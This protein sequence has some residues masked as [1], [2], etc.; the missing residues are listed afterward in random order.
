MLLFKYKRFIH[1]FVG[2]DGFLL[3]RETKPKGRAK[4]YFHKDF[5]PKFAQTSNQLTWARDLTSAL[6]KQLAWASY[7]SPERVEVFKSKQQIRL[8]ELQLS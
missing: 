5:W 1:N 7:S 6:S 8:G 3:D 2:F 4:W